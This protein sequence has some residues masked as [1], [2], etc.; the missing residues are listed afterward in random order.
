MTSTP[1]LDP[2]RTD[3][4]RSF[5]VVEA[6]ADAARRPPVL[7]PARRRVA[8]GAAA[9]LLLA[10]GIVAV[11][12]VGGDAP[13][14]IAVE[15]DGE[16][17]TIRLVDIDADPDA[18]VADL[19]A[20]GFTA[21]RQPLEVIETDGGSLSSVHVT[22]EHGGDG[23]VAL[24]HGRQGGGAHGIVGLTVSV[25]EG[26]SP[27]PPDVPEH[28]GVVVEADPAEALPSGG[29]VG[30]AEADLLDVGVRFEDDGGVSLR[31]GTDASIIVQTER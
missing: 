3:Q 10:G 4:I 16:W 19:I 12:A 9:A 13:A 24:A 27:P 31:R 18:V 28:G 14:A 20:A 11:Q 26:V 8:V 6:A 25:P 5:L 29:G 15:V 1:T 22:D 21:E 2:E 30:P 7:T 23:V 17:T